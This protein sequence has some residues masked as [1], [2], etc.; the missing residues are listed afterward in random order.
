MSAPAAVV[1]WEAPEEFR[2]GLEELRRLLADPRDVVIFGHKDADGDTLGS[3]LAFAEGLRRAGHRA[4]VVIPPPHP[5]LYS[6][7][8]GFDDLLRQPPP[9]VCGAI[10]LFVDASNVERTDQ[11]RA[12]LQAT[13]VNIDHHASNTGFG[14]LNLVDP[15]AAAVGQMCLGI[16][17]RLGWEITPT[18]ATCLYAAILT[19]T[20]GFRH[21]NTDPSVLQDAARLAAL[22]AVPAEIA[23]HIYESRPLS[24]MRLQSISL[25]SVQVEAGGRIVWARVTRQMLHRAGAVMSESEGIIDS[26]NS[27]AGIS[28]AIVFKEVSTNLVKIS[29]R[30]RDEVDA[31]EI[32]AGFGG[33]GHR[34]AAGAELRMPL[35]EAI[36]TV[37]EVSTEAVERA[38][39]R[40]QHR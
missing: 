26:L 8:P 19:D 10:S 29:V 6:W 39:G 16:F 15:E 4:W 7:V 21:D 37:L 35:R 12:D 24:T 30:S 40:S 33:G 11:E 20:G 27:I 18:M 2:D 17:D 25:S 36:D 14:T 28:V 22:G 38:S 31:A 9:E 23:A 34:R 5:Q 3:A 1:G 13:V 32:C